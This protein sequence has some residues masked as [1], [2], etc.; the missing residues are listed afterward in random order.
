MV[1]LLFYA[2][3]AIAMAWIDAEHLKRNEYILNHLSRSVLRFLIFI[4]IGT[5]SVN[6]SI[7]F[8]L[9]F[10]VLFD[11]VLNFMRGLNIFYLGGISKVDLFFK[12]N[13]Y[14]YVFLKIA[15]MGLIIYTYKF[16]LWEKIKN[17]LLNG[18]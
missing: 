8:A 7:L 10:W 1:K 4:T 9:V 15:C 5:Y 13:M 18:F 17:A 14:L 3:I 11:Q 2:L 12:R 16:N 6:D